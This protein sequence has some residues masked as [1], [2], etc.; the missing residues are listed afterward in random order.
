MTGVLKLRFSPTYAPIKMF[1]WRYPFVPP[2]MFTMTTRKDIL[3]LA[4]Q[5]VL[6]DRNTSYGEPEDNFRTISRFWS[7]YLG[8]ELCPQDVAAMMVMLKIARIRVN[9]GHIDSMVDI[10][11]YAACMG[12]LIN[13][14]NDESH[15]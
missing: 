13:K 4:A 15:A 11:G 9:P 14:T 12:E 10:A 8:V 5:A 1:D 2:R 6:T 3:D 7:V